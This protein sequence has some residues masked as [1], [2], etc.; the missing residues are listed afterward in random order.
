MPFGK[1][2]PRW[3]GL[4]VGMF[5]AGSGTDWVPSY[6]LVDLLYRSGSS[7][8]TQQCALT[9]A[10]PSC[11]Q[12]R[13]KWPDTTVHPAVNLVKL[14]VTELELKPRTFLDQPKV[15]VPRGEEG[16]AARIFFS[17]APPSFVPWA[18]PRPSLVCVWRARLEPRAALAS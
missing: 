8:P 17:T 14:Q 1:E 15:K 2:G 16:S 12:E 6:E 13:L 9:I 3:A 7:G 18:R 10:P 4:R 5:S 11:H